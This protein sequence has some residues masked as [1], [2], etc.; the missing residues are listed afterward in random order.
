MDWL[1]AHYTYV[2]MIVYLIVNEIVLHNPAI[3]SG[4]IPNLI[5][6]ALKS[7]VVGKSLPPPNG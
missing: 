3:V 1:L 5:W 2:L 6:N 4:S 7:A